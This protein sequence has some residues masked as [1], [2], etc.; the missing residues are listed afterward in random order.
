MQCWQIK[1][2]HGWLFGKEQVQKYLNYKYLN[3]HILN[4]TW[5]DFKTIVQ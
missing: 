2:L 3:E 5:R 1:T 4:F